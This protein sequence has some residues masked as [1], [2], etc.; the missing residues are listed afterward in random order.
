VAIA[1]TVNQARPHDRRWKTML[2]YVVIEQR[3][4]LG[5]GPRVSIQANCVRWRGFIRAIVMPRRIDTERADL[6][7]APQ[8]A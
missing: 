8:F 6:N 4:G 7:P 2:A 3:L 1:A 5:F